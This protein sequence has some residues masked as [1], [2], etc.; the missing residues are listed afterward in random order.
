MTVSTLWIEITIAGSLYLTALVFLCLRVLG[1]AHVPVVD[2][3]L[4]PYLAVG[5][6][7]GSYILG[8]LMHRL[9]QVAT[10]YRF[11]FTHW[12]SRKSGPSEVLRNPA[13][14]RAW[15]NAVIWQFGSERVNK[16]LDF[17]FALKSLFRSIRV[18]IPLLGLCFAWWLSITPA[19]DAISLVI[20]LTVIFTA[21]LVPTYAEQ[22]INLERVRREALEIARQ[23]SGIPR[24]DDHEPGVAASAVPTTTLS[25][26]SR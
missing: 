13:E 6:V 17:Q 5:A 11:E 3:D 24:S 2:E 7:A 22:L 25:Q 4:L 23:A 16:E 18:S 15:A 21:L 12:L 20:A 1:V 8:M 26:E 10:R 9:L 14:E 19:R